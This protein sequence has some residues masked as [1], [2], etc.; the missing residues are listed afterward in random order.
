M[1]RKRHLIRKLKPF[2]VTTTIPK[3]IIHDGKALNFHRPCKEFR[4]A[5]DNTG[6]AVI[7]CPRG[8]LGVKTGVVRAHRLA[9][10]LDKPFPLACEVDHLCR[11]RICCE[12]THHQVIGP[13]THGKLSKGDQVNGKG[14]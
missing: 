7:R 6:Y 8:T 5:T 13:K 11:N 14:N 2:L 9:K 1:L 4:G 10:Y 3:G 12:P